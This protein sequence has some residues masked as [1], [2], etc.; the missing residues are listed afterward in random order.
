MPYIPKA[1]RLFGFTARFINKCK[2]S[3]ILAL[4]KTKRM[5]RKRCLT[6]LSAILLIGLHARVAPAQTRAQD[7]IR[8][9]SFADVP[10]LP[11]P[12]QLD[13]GNHAV[14]ITN[15]TQWAQKRQWIE[16]GY[17]YWVSGSRPP[18]PKSMDSRIVSKSVNAEGV[19]IETV[20]LRFGPNKQAKMTVELMI[21]PAGGKQLPVFMTQW[22]HRAWA[23]VAVRRGYIG[24]VYAGADAKDDTRNYGKVFPDYDFATL[25]KRAWGASRVIDY[26]Y[27]LPVV[28][29]NGIALA[30]HSRNGKQSLMAAAFDKRIKAVISS[31]GGTGGEM[32]FRFS[33]DRFDSESVEEITH[34]FPDWFSPRLNLFTGREQKLPVDQNSLMALIA[35]RG[36]MM[37][38]AI[39]ETQGNPWG[40]EQSYKSVKTVYHFLNADANIAILMRRGR[41]QHAARDIDNFLDF[42][43]YIFGRS[44]IAP[45]NR[46]YYNYSFARWK[47]RSGEAIDPL[48][49][50]KADHAFI[51]KYTS[52][53]QARTA[54]QDSLRH[55]IQWLLG[56][57]PP[58]VTA[59]VNFSPFL[60]R[61]RTY[62]DD[63]LSEV[64]GPVSFK[65]AGIKQMKFG[66]YHPLGDDLWGTV[67][68]PPGS[69][70][71]DSVG[72][73][74]PLVV[75]LHEYSYATGY[76]RRSAGIIQHFLKAGYAVLAFDLPGFGTRIEEAKHFYDRYPH[77]SKMGQMVSDT[78]SVISDV[79]HRMPFIDSNRIFLAGYALGGTVALFTAALDQHVAGVAAVSALSSLRSDTAGTEGLQHYYSLHGLIPRLGFFA[80]DKQ[81]IPIDFDG[82]LSCIAPRPLLIIAPKK[83][84]H[85][86]I[87]SVQK[88]MRT[89]T[90]VYKQYHAEDAVLL[91][92][93][94]TFNHFTTAMQQQISDWL[95][96]RN[97]AP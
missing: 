19:T 36:L 71:H 72:K 5:N 69:V 68:F 35:P 49:F 42:S 1:K 14:A 84:R 7:S 33:D 22:N 96:D 51:G 79:Y 24:C 39:T 78:R 57:H 64:I 65:D 83:D 43:D 21:P 18:A 62:P 3:R 26:L 27:T 31:S 95:K 2:H 63:Y 85:H 58:G 48:R 47:K 34:K 94:D 40:V 28:D 13:E 81:R 67:F 76:H 92:E 23:Q 4:P 46:L 12:L 91:K 9:N 37:V 50:P 10:L 66:P 41:H 80:A 20:E 75:Y 45:E 73:K 56:D 74:W 70:V 59:Q 29:T 53:R 32:T 55:R 30:G 90:E 97:G 8:I 11:D 15:R 82:I 25:M 88:I 93:P 44:S 17:Q 87:A 16:K 52:S 77:W 38:S 61:N 54:L 6:L 86:S 60:K 89:T